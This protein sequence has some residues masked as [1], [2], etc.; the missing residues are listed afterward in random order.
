MDPEIAVGCI[1]AETA[2]RMAA[3]LDQAVVPRAGDPLPALW[4][5][6]LLTPIAR[7][8]E[9]GPDGHPVLA[10][11]VPEIQAPMRMWA[12][13]RLRFLAPVCVG[14][15]VERC[16]TVHQ[17]QRKQGR[18]GALAFVTFRHEYRVGG[19]LVIE[20]DQDLVYR[21]RASAGSAP[22]AAPPAAGVAQFSRTVE[23]HTTLLFR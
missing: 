16:S 10:E 20:D 19:Q 14:D 4:H 1:D 15:V 12:G 13:S 21:E 22:P 9:L 7:A 6:M 3:T 5:W 2:A 18:S 17:V 11:V 8:S 23:P